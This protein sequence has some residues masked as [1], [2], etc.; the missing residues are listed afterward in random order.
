MAEK[1]TIIKTMVDDMDGTEFDPDKG[2]GRA[3]TFGWRG[4]EYRMDLTTKNA[5]KLD[6]LL[7]PYAEHAMRVGTL[8]AAKASASR[9][10]S[11]RTGGDGR[12]RGGG[13]G[14][15]RSK[16]ELDE[17]RTWARA[18][19]HTVADSGLIPRK[20]VEAW[21]KRDQRE[22][23][24][25]TPAAKPA[26]AAEKAADAQSPVTP[27][28]DSKPGPA[29]VKPETPPEPVKA[30]PSVSGEER[31]PD[32]APGTP[33]FQPPV[34]EPAGQGRRGFLGRGSDAR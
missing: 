20:V 23:I 1:V 28:P 5:D 22:V 21:E 2:E 25:S 14:M 24:P 8:T 9:G 31:K 19:G 6:G 32:P 16:E 3:V 30:T 12:R 10:G 27:V 4:K 13:Q 7:A 17:I 11:A 15:G 33:A 34:T 29:A 26:A 18:N